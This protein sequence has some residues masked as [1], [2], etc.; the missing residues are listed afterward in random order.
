MAYKSFDNSMRGFVDNE[1]RKRDANLHEE[2]EKEFSRLAARQSLSGSVGVNKTTEMCIDDLSERIN[3]VYDK[4]KQIVEAEKLNYSENLKEFARRIFIEFS[5]KAKVSC[6]EICRLNVRKINE[7]SVKGS[8]QRIDH[9]FE[10]NQT[11]LLGEIDLYFTALKNESSS[12][13]W[14]KLKAFLDKFFWKFILPTI[15]A[16]LGVLIGKYL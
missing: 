13:K 12:S 8:L 9:K 11:E 10:I 2:I 1:Y 4:I 14:D 5:E 7:G 6:S 15:T 16:I 3:F